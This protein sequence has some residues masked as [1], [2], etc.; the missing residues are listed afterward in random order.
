MSFSSN[1][2]PVNITNSSEDTSPLMDDY[3]G[4]E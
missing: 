2:S 3:I 1:D 4:D